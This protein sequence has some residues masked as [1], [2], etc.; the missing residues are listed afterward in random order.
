MAGRTKKYDKLMQPISISISEHLLEKATFKAKQLGMNRSEYICHLITLADENLEEIL[1]QLKDQSKKIKELVKEKDTLQRILDKQTKIIE[2][3][4]KRTKADSLYGALVRDPIVGNIVEGM[5]DSL[6]ARFF[7]N[8]EQ[9]QEETS[10]YFLE[11]LAKEVVVPFVKVELSKRKM[12]ILRLK[13][14]KEL[15]M[16][17]LTILSEQL[18]DEWK[19]EQKDKQ[20]QKMTKLKDE[21]KKAKERIAW[22][23]NQDWPEEQK[24]LF[25]SKQ[26][27]FIEEAEK[28]IKK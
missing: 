1:K 23:T 17:E 5:R 16:T 27:K 19:K 24:E 7:S 4:S 26:L 11:S 12:K 2:S 9:S 15:V 3:L 6:K 18:F 8:F 13:A 22:A 21:I 10:P 28:I 14:L 20:A 25:V